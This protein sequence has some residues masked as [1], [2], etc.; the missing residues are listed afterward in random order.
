MALDTYTNLKSTIANYLNRDDL[1]AYLGDFITLTEARLNREL[2]VREMVNT[3]TSIT[4]VAGTQS[5]A[6]PTGYIEATTVI[7]QSDPYCTLR[8]ISN[9]DFY[10]KYNA[11]QSRGKPT[12]FTILGS[13]ILLGVAPDTATTLQINYYKTLTALSDSN[14]TNDILTNYPELYLYGSLA[15]SAPF[16]MQDDR[17]N[18]WATLYKEAIKNANETSSRGSTTSSPLQ[19]STPQVA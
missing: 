12:Y 8:F 18:T 6:L 3:D 19:M 14:A 11:S 15:E 2:R 17:I 9:S 7:F 1:T 10:N 16:I 13:N 4:T 5:Y